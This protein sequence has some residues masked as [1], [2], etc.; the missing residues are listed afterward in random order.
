MLHRPEN[1]TSA[2]DRPARRV[3]PQC[4]WQD[5]GECE[6]KGIGPLFLPAL[7]ALL[8]VPFS[9][10]CFAVKF[11]TGEKGIDVTGIQPGVTR[12]NAEA[13][14]SPPVREWT[15]STGIRYTTYSYDAGRPPNMP[16]AVAAVIMDVISVGIFELIVAIKEPKPW[17]L[18]HITGR[19]VISYDDRAVVLGI[20]DE[21]D[22]LPP[23][24]RSGPQR[25][26]RAFPDTEE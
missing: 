10:G 26:K 20:F 3:R 12:A 17:T 25:W 9:T 15:S 24:G 13:I 14:L 6:I 22:E 23:D 19:V 18:D 16:E 5:R 1:M 7:V 21:F 4:S 11:A 8:L 2:V